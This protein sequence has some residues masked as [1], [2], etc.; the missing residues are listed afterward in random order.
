MSPNRAGGGAA[1]RKNSILAASRMYLAQESTESAKFQ[2]II[3]HAAAYE[4]EFLGGAEDLEEPHDVGVL[5]ALEH[6]ALRLQHR[7]VALLQRRPAAT[8]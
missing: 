1:S 3:V 7:L 4:D 8:P 2:R 6:R 5:D